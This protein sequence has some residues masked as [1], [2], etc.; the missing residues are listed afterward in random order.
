MLKSTND[1]AIAQFYVILKDG[2]NVVNIWTLSH[3]EVRL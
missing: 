1:R 2:V 3:F